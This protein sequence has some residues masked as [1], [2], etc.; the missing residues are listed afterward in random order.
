MH[1]G[2]EEK[3]LTVDVPFCTVKHRGCCAVVVESTSRIVGNSEKK[4]KNKII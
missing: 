1:G 4:K 2:G 3:M